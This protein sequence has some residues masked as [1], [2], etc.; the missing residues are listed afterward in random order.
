MVNSTTLLIPRAEN[1]NTN[2]KKSQEELR[3]EV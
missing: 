1:V 3:D 2:D